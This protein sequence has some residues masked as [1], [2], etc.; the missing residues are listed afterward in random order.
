MLAANQMLASLTKEQRLLLDEDGATQKSQKLQKDAGSPEAN[1]CKAMA[2]ADKG[3]A[4]KAARAGQEQRQRRAEAR[5][6]EK[7]S[8]SQSSCIADDAL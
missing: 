2:I 1:Q 7:Q 5:A 6:L 8:A 3:K 4:E